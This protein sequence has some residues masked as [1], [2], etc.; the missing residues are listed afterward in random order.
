LGLGFG[1]GT[2]NYFDIDPSVR[3]FGI[4]WESIFGR[5]FSLSLNANIFGDQILS[6]MKIANGKSERIQENCDLVLVNRILRDLGSLQ[7]D[8]TSH[9]EAV[10][11][12]RLS[13]S[14]RRLIQKEQLKYSTQT[15]I[16]NWTPSK[17]VVKSRSF[18][19]PNKSQGNCTKSRQG[20]K[21]KK[22][23]TTNLDKLTLAPGTKTPIRSAEDRATMTGS[24]QKKLLEPSN[25]I[26]T[27]TKATGGSITTVVSAV[28]HSS[29][30]ADLQLS[31]KKTSF[32]Q[33]VSS[34]L[35]NI[36]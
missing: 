8:V 19:D 22:N 33:N 16:N 5:C 9:A 11:Q 28:P 26:V 30:L 2:L 17:P 27:A 29:S 10:L 13:K 6:L 18:R 12:G 24:D 36:R 15:T 14:Q 7:A 34:M 31:K 32:I 35:K 1:R 25:M 4:D 20:I 23:K 21:Y 3:F